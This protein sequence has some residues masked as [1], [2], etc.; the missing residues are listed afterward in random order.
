MAWDILQ[1]RPVADTSQLHENGTGLATKANQAPSVAS[2]P[3]PVREG[4]D[5]FRKEIDW[6]CNTKH[7]LGGVKLPTIAT[8]QVLILAQASWNE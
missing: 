4:E 6:R 3:Q 8:Q 5:P 1:R 2:Q 7:W